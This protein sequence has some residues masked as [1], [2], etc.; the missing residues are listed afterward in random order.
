VAVGRCASLPPALRLLP[1]NYANR[2][3][4]YNR[5]NLE[6]SYITRKIRA[7]SKRNSER[8]KK[9]WVMD[10][11]KRNALAKIDPVCIGRIVMRVVV[12]RNETFAKEAVIYDFDSVRSYRKKIK[13]L[14]L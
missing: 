6:M 5:V 8:A 2:R 1:S 4:C 12:I 14:G 9:R 11:A 7:A 3:T 13:S 10:R